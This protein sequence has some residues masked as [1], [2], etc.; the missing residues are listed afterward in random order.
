MERLASLNTTFIMILEKEKQLHVSALRPS[1]GWTLGLKEKYLLLRLVEENYLLETCS[2][3]SFSKNIM[4]IVL[5]PANLSI[6]S[7]VEITQ[8]DVNT[9]HCSAV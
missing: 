3:F 1:S 8:L 6:Y 2:C 5:R 4:K 9:K 7:K